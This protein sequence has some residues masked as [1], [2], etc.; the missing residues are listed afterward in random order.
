MPLIHSSVT[1]CTA[2][3]AHLDEHR[4]GGLGRC[5]NQRCLKFQV[6]VRTPSAVP[7]YSH[8]IKNTKAKARRVAP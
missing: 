4:R 5:I 1:R 2:C 3:G 7:I 8:R 6:L